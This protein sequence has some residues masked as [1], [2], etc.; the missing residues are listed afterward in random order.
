MSPPKIKEI[1]DQALSRER[2][3]WLATNILPHETGLR[4]WLLCQRRLLL[5]ADDVIQESYTLISALA[6]VDHISNPR[7]YLFQTAKS[8]LLTE[9]RRSKVVSIEAIDNFENFG[10]SDAPSPEQHTSDRQELRLLSEA[11]DALPL[12]VRDAFKMRKIDGMAQNQ[13]AKRLGLT[14][15]A[16]EMRV[17]RALR[18][19]V[20]QFGRGGNPSPRASRV[21]IGRSG[22]T[23]GAKKDQF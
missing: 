22:T 11:L 13:I 10:V 17:A 2:A 1:A 3:V 6:C 20:E 15:K 8:I 4:R 19:L 5:D 14:E 21:Q 7:A 12:Q 23:R 16:V 18:L 9:V